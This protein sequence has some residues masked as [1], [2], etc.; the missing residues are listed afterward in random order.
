[1]AALKKFSVVHF[2]KDNTI[3]AV[4]SLWLN[5]KRSSCYFPPGSRSKL[6]KLRTGPTSEPDKESWENLVVKFKCTA[7]TYQKAS[8][9]ATH[10]QFT[11]TV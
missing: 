1:M 11:S 7:D 3:E 6:S 2:M 9:Q 5:K 10:L 8:Q 4:P